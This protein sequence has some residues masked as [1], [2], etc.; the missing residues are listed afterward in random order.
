VA[1]LL[2]R[3]V[4]HREGRSPATLS[5]QLALSASGTLP[6][7][8]GAISLIAGAGGGLYWVLGGIVGALV[9]TVLNA[10]VLLIEILR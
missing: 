4:P 1:A 5:G 8:V 2:S 10:W 7:V 9:G 6:F 3:S